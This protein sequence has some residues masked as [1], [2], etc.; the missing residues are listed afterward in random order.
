[1][2]CS[3][4]YLSSRAFLSSVFPNPMLTEL[5]PAAEDSSLLWSLDNFPRKHL[6]ELGREP[7]A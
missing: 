5:L 3:K 6:T 1:M 4:G 7:G 2:A